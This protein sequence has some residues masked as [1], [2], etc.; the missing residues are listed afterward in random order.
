MRHVHR[1]ERIELLKGVWLFERCT[2][3]ELEALARIS[4]PEVVQA[5]RNLAVEGSIGQEFVVVVEGVAVATVDGNEIGR[6]GPGSFFGELALLDPGPRTATVHADTD[7]LVLVMSR[8]EFDTLVDR[9]IPSVGRRMLVT[10]AQR[11]RSERARA[12]E[13]RKAASAGV[14]T[15]PESG[16]P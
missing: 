1:D 16:V 2:R 4:T 11:L 14:G 10:L 3:K 5:G 15:G 6:I 8:V 7:M 12:E 13:F 9:A